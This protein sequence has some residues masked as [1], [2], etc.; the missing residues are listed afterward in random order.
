MHAAGFFHAQTS[1]TP[2]S[3]VVYNEGAPINLFSADLGRVFNGC[4]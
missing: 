4:T 2:L 3:L 1:L